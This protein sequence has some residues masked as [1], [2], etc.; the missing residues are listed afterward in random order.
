MAA[1]MDLTAINVSGTLYSVPCLD[2]LD[3]RPL[4]LQPYPSDG[5][6]VEVRRGMD[7]GNRGMKLARDLRF[8][9][10]NK[11]LVKWRGAIALL[12][13]PRGYPAKG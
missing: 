7:S 1:R 9:R 2:D 5:F 11:T 8:G 4:T 12:R 6:C 3:E 13:A 10:L